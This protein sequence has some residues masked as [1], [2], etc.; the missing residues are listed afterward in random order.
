[1]AKVEGTSSETIDGDIY[2]VFFDGKEKEALDRALDTRK[3]E[4]ELYWRRAT[5]FW[6]FI[7]ATLGA[8]FVAYSSSSDVRKD[9]LVIICCLGVVFSFAWFCV[10]R[11]S[12]YWQ[13]N[14]EKHVDLLEDKTI[15]P[16]FKVVLSRNDDMN[17]CE[18][19][20]EFATGP[21]PLSVS[22]I[23]QLIS[24]FIFVL[25]VVLLIN[26]LQPLSFELPI[27]WFYVVI[28]GVSVF[29]CCMFVFSAKTYRG[30]YYHKATIRKSRIKPNE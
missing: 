17:S 28:V 30:G 18:K 20:M 15:G 8:F 25:W 14:W 29:F 21:K 5:Y 7:G 10:N 11:G 2:E 12:K 9:L 16:L 19:I 27:K 22:K 13:E 26:S 6:T 23:N 4:I 1:M 24:L 3:F